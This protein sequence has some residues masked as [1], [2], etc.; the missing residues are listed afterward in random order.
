MV[1]MDVWPT[2][3]AAGSV[4]TEARW[5]KM[6][7]L[8][9]PS[10]VVAGQGGEM[11][12]S[13]A[14]PNLT[15]Q[16]GACWVDGHYCELTSNQ[17]LTATANGIAVVRFNPAANTAEL[18]WRDGVSTPSQS[19]TG[20]WELPIAA[21]IGSA[22]VDIRPLATVNGAWIPFTPQLVGA[23]AGSTIGN[24]SILGRYKYLGEKTVTAAIK[25][26]AGTTT[27]YNAGTARMSLPRQANVSIPGLILGSALALTTTGIY[28]GVAVPDTDRNFLTILTPVSTS[29]PSI[30]E[31]ANTHLSTNSVLEVSVTYEIT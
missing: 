27:I 29:N 12:L 21:T 30:T 9:S 4:A 17:V 13:L 24:G 26:T 7:R 28:A 19:P 3:G 22:L 14:Y 11:A 18:L 6:G 10:G 31:I 20:T 1:A 25:F 16:T 8:W 2:D 5:R 23:S 15:V